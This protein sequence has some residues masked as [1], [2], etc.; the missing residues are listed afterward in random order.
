MNKELFVDIL[1]KPL[2]RYLYSHESHRFMQDNDPKHTSH[3]VT[4][5]L[6]LS[7]INWNIWQELKER[8]RIR[9]H[10]PNSALRHSGQLL[11]QKMH[12]VHNYVHQMLAEG[13][14]MSD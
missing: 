2:V 11:Q 9:K 4:D 6:D 8:I 14:P 13:N 7:C 3:H 5:F 1:D 10:N 12:K